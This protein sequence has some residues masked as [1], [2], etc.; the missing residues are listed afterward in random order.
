MPTLHWFT[1]DEDLRTASRVPYRLLEEV[2][3][4]SA[5]EPDTS[6][7][8]IQGDN[9]EALKALLPFYAGRVKCIYID[10]PYNTHSAF[11]HYDDSL[12][13]TQWLAMMWPRLELLRE[14]L[15]DEGSI[16]INIDDDEGHYLK[17]IADEIYGRRNFIVN[18]SR[19]KQK[20][21]C[22]STTLT[23][24]HSRLGCI[25]TSGDTGGIGSRERTF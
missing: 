24:S 1:R 20:S 25:R 15:T 18:F 10:P 12:E 9:L 21:R 19:L 6:N 11:E 8:L 16:W 4:L 2:P 17:I 7:M 23:P 3:A 5:G 22:L 13:H 14:F